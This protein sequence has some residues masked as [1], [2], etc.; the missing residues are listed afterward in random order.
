ML[1]HYVVALFLRL[2]RLPNTFLAW[3]SL[4]SQE[5]LAEDSI[6]LRFILAPR[7]QWQVEI[8]NSDN[9]PTTWYNIKIIS[10][11]HSLQ[12]TFMNNFVSISALFSS[13]LIIVTPLWNGKRNHS[14]MPKRK[15]K[16][17]PVCSFSTFI[18]IDW[19]CV[20]VFVC[21]ARVLAPK[22]RTTCS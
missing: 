3:I 14:Y 16:T 1:L 15:K 9:N 22:V 12:L 13:L 18:L 2:F 8:K 5:K 6:W 21:C 11:I 17:I 19:W 10:S 20:C 7:S 4:L